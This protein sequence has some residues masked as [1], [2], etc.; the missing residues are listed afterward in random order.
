MF[1]FKLDDANNDPKIDVPAIINA[2]AIKINP[3]ISS[4]YA[5]NVSIIILLPFGIMFNICAKDKS[6]I[7]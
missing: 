3:P 4:P 1:V 2:S 7:S 6:W 5:L